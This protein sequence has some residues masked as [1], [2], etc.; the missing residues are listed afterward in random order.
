[1]TLSDDNYFSVQSYF[2]MEKKKKVPFNPGH[3]KAVYF[4]QAF[5]GVFEIN[6]CDQIRASFLHY[7]IQIY[8]KGL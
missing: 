4:T 1:M 2:P 8:V 6:Q 3:S 7:F 5:N